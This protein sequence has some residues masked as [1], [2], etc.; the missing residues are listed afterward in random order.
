MQTSDNEPKNLGAMRVNRRNDTDISQSEREAPQRESHS[1][2]LGETSSGP[3]DHSE[4]NNE[5]RGEVTGFRLTLSGI[6]GD[7]GQDSD[8]DECTSQT[9][10]DSSTRTPPETPAQSSGISIEEALHTSRLDIDRNSVVISHRSSL[11]VRISFAANPEPE[12]DGAVEGEGPRRVSPT[13][14]WIK[15][16]YDEIGSTE[17]SGEHYTH[18]MLIVL[19]GYF[20]CADVTEQEARRVAD[21]LHRINDEFLICVSSWEVLEHDQDLQSFMWMVWGALLEVVV[22]MDYRDNSQD[23]VVLLVKELLKTR[24]RVVEKLKVIGVR[25]SL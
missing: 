8:D 25:P 22:R 19:W 4:G 14:P 3:G 13:D 17:F 15:F 18:R 24:V 6:R 12:E 20:A 9:S 7:L 23:S 11:E 5:A 16:L 10:T 21:N 2:S 1:S